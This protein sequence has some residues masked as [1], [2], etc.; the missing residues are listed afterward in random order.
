MKEYGE[1]EKHMK[2]ALVDVEKREKHLNI[3]EQEVSLA[4]RSVVRT[5]ARVPV[6]MLD[7]THAGRS[8]TRLRQ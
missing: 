1:L 8:E 5:S 7:S 6:A 4:F 2:K 3:N